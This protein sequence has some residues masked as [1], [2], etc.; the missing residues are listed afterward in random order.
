MKKSEASDERKSPQVQQRRRDISLSVVVPIFNESACIPEFFARIEGVRSSAKFS[1]FEL[2]FVDDGS[3]DDS[4]EILR[5]LAGSYPWVHSRLLTRN[6]GHQI[7]VSAGLDLAS[8]DFIAIIDGD[9][10][11][12]PEL[13]PLLVDKAL[14][15]HVDVVYGERSSRDGESRF[16]LYSASLFYRLIRKV[17]G[18]DIP[19]NAGD[20]RVITRKVLTELQG[21]RESHRFLRGMIPWLGFS[22]VGH[23]YHR[24]SRHAGESK[25]PLKKMLLLA[26]DAMASFSVLPIRLVQLASLILISVGGVG[27]LVFGLPSVLGYGPFI[28]PIILAYATSLVGLLLLGVGIVGGYVHRIQSDTVSR[29]LYVVDEDLD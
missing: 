17:S 11:D 7:A 27:L 14:E 13:I 3:S 12:P 28:T 22:A 21:L 20:F 16:K 10:Q 25:Y 15:A 29:P 6:F 23:P 9:L 1:E 24:D 26:A 19:L 18:L 8:G 2:I 5:T 4:K